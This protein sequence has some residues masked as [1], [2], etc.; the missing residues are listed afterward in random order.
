MTIR[1]FDLAEDAAAVAGLFTRNTLTPVTVEEFV[2]SVQKYPSAQPV[3]RLVAL[4]DNNVVGYVRTGQYAPNPKN[5]FRVELIVDQNSRGCGIG[6]ELFDQATRYLKKFAPLVMLS[7]AEESDPAG[8]QFA[9]KQGFE[10]IA[11][12]YNSYLNLRNFDLEH[13][14]RSSLTADISA[15]EFTTLARLNLPDAT[16]RKFYDQFLKAFNGTPGE[17]YF[18]LEEW[19]DFDN[20]VFKSKTLDKDGYGVALYQGEFV[21]FSDVIKSAAAQ[22]GEMFTGFTGVVPEHRGIGLAYAM[23]VKM[24][25]YCISLG[26]KRLKTENDDRNIPML[27][28]NRKLGFEEHPG[29]VIFVRDLRLGTDSPQR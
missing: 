22:D 3:K 28:V 8:I 18:G 4:A 16:R 17:E 25:A 13:H 10:R 15:Y 6:T 19:E 1:E 9:E 2:E 23:K 20:V 5:S 27:K 29:E 24:I 12:L 11:S 26:A 14:S 21:G 7:A